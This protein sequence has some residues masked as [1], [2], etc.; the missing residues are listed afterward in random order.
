MR[1]GRLLVQ[2]NFTRDG[3]FRHDPAVPIPPLPD[4]APIQDLSQLEPEATRPTSRARIWCAG[5]TD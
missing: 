4:L 2:V 3:A 1:L 5:R